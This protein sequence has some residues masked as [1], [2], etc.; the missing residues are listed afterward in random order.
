M[1]MKEGIEKLKAVI[2]DAKTRQAEANKEAKR[3][4][5][6]MNDF[7]NNKD[8]KLVELQTEVESLKKMLS[9]QSASI[10]PLYQEMREAMVEAEQCES[11]LVAAQKQLQEAEEALS[12]QREELNEVLAQQKSSKVCRRFPVIDVYV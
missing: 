10:K 3:I 9:K 12:A 2:A 5:K 4:E 8:S 1:E 11:D 7:A 6:D